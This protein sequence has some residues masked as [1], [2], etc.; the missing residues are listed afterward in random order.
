M[1]RPAVDFRPSL[2]SDAIDLGPRLTL[3]DKREL[4]AAGDL[5]PCAALLEGVVWSEE[6]WTARIDGEVA[7]MWGVRP[8]DLMGW[9]G[10]PWML[11]SEA[12]AQNGTLLLR[13]SRQ[14]VARWRGMYPV[15]RN[16]VDARHER[17]IRWLRWLGF[18]IGPAVP[19]GRGGLP[20]HVFTMRASHV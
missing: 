6:A 12:V 4:E 11:G 10:V 14:I 7:C 17:S 5:P 9:T 18:E 15:L 19:L 3:E 16:M 2:P 1:Y 8:A 20:F 13:H